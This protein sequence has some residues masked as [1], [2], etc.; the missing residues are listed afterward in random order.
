MYVGAS[1]VVLKA[2]SRRS[3]FFLSLLFFF[4]LSLYCASLSL[5]LSLVVAHVSILQTIEESRKERFMG[6]YH[7]HPFDVDEQHSHCYLSNTDLS[8]QLQWQRAED[9]HGNSSPESNEKR[10]PCNALAVSV[11]CSRVT[12]TSKYTCTLATSGVVGS[13]SIS[14]SQT[15]ALYY[16]RPG[17]PW[18]AIVVDPLRS[19]AK[20]RPELGAFRAYPPEFTAPPNECPDGNA[21]KPP[22]GKRKSASL[23]V[24][25]LCLGSSPFATPPVLIPLG[26]LY[27]ASAHVML[28]FFSLSVFRQSGDG[29]HNPRRALGGVLEPL[30][31]TRGRVLH[32][33]PGQG[34]GGHFV[35]KLPVDAHAGVDP[36]QRARKPRAFQVEAPPPFVAAAPLSLFGA[37]F[38]LFPFIVLAF[39]CS[40]VAPCCA[41]CSL[42]LGL[43]PSASAS[44]SRTKS[45][46]SSAPPTPRSAASVRA[47]AS[48][49]WPPPA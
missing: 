31:P 1:C 45:S 20:S 10:A 2:L 23:R 6:W 35:Q 18:L 15:M 39:G 30:L 49:A 47:A 32:E 12:G 44:A 38:A 16:A 19:L 25:L 7:S 46:R 27:L 9:P 4:A 37:L 11:R 22:F 48:E 17:N 33:L 21:L 29:R 26:T 5:S 43:L 28:F 41:Y 24:Q 36:E 14:L 40:D 3:L 8:T 13:F 34:R 42:H